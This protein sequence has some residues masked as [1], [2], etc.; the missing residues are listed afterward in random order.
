MDV[1]QAWFAATDVEKNWALVLAVEER[2]ASKG[3]AISREFGRHVDGWR[4]EVARYHDMLD[5]TTVEGE[6]YE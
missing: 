5:G 6:R 3:R 1:S 4:A 2:W